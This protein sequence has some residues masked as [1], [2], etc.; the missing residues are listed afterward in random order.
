MLLLL[1]LACPAP[2][3]LDSEDIALSPDADQDGYGLD[4]DCNDG[5]AA[6]H[7]EA[8]E[9]C[10]G[11]DDN[12]DQQVDEDVLLVFYADSDGDGY[13][14]AA[15]PSE[16]CSAG[17]GLVA[18][19]TDCDDSL[20]EIHPGA[21][22]LCNGLDDDCDGTVDISATDASVLYPDV[23]E[24]GYGD[25]SAPLFSCP[26]EGYVSPEAGIDCDDSDP[27]IHP[28][29]VEICNGIDDNCNFQVDE[30]A[31][32]ALRWYLDQDGDGYGDQPVYSCTQPFGTVENTD[33][34]NDSDAAV[35]PGASEYCG[36]GID[37]NC[38]G[39]TDG[40]DAVDAQ[41]WYA[42]VDGDQYGD[43]SLSTLSCLPPAGHV[44]DGGD[45]HDQNP[46]IHPGASE[47]CNGNDDDC[48]GLI[49]ESDAL[50]ATWWYSDA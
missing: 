22:E 5:D 27:A 23:D 4:S 36:N 42:D 49:D 15:A 35:S 19:S 9:F 32:N 29:A 28:G 50:D 30:D 47:W 10:N 45:C 40:S 11:V 31:T 39:Q 25:P 12:C 38:D 34:C 7:P 44:P 13:G 21:P 18:T 3:D 16:A 1:L 48:D 2:K 24:D 37:D 33:D 8:T 46:S 43:P 14:D 6:I 20:A 17:S 26:A 41:F